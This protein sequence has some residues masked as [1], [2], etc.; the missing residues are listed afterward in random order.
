[1]SG[2][3]EALAYEKGTAKAATTVRKRKNNSLLHRKKPDISFEHGSRAD[4]KTAQTNLKEIVKQTD[5]D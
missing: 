5:F 2:P 3:E 1:M 4:T